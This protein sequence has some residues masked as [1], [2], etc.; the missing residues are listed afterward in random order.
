[1]TGKKV[2]TF[3]E[4]F[5]ELVESSPKSRS[6]I[7]REFGVAKQTVSAWLTGQNSP[8][9]PVVVSLADY[10]GVSLEWLNGFD[11]PKYEKADD[12]Y[13]QYLKLYYEDKVEQELLETY[14]SLS[15]HGKNLLL[16]RA[17]ELKILYGKKPEDHPAVS[18]SE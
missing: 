10:F 14:R 9:L 12:G 17:K 1:M 16:D 2:S 15:L 6:D 8:R 7:A 13:Q 3:R 11:V 18:V 4:R 5:M